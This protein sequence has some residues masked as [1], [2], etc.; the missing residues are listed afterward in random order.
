MLFLHHQAEPDPLS[1]LLAVNEVLISAEEN[2]TL[3]MTGNTTHSLSLFANK[4]SQGLATTDKTDQNSISFPSSNIKLTCTV[5]IASCLSHTAVQGLS[6]SSHTN[7]SISAMGPN[8]LSALRNLLFVL[9]LLTAAS[10]Q[11]TF[12]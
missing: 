12:N 4:L 6:I 11:P 8:L 7:C 10:L 2:Y 3:W 9:Y 1:F 5:S